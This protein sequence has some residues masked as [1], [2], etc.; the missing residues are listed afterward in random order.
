MIKYILPLVLVAGFAN[1]ETYTLH[2]DGQNK[3]V[4]DKGRPTLRSLLDAAKAGKTKSTEFGVALPEENRDLAIKRLEVLRDIL[5]KSLDMG[6]ILV[7]SLEADSAPT[8]TVQVTY[9]K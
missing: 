3:W 6:V 1:A 4:G 9:P 8:N 2:Y 7:E 5:T